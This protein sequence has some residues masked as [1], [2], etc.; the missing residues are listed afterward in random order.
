MNP[1][2]ILFS[3]LVLT[4]CIVVTFITHNKQT[5]LSSSSLPINQHWL[6]IQYSASKPFLW[7]HLPFDE[8]YELNA[9]ACIEL[10]VASILRH[11]Q[12]SFN[13]CIIDDHSFH[14][15]LPNWTVDIQSTPTTQKWSLRKLAI[16]KLL[17]TY[18]GICIPPSFFCL[19][20]L[21]HL[22]HTPM[23]V[24]TNINYTLSS[25]HLKFVPDLN[26]M[27]CTAGNKTMY[28]L[29]QFIA[30]QMST[31]FSDAIR[32]EDVYGKW[33][34]KHN[35]YI[36]QLSPKTL[37]VALEN[38][39]PIYPTTLLN[40]TYIQFD[41]SM[42]GIWIPIEQFEQRI[43]L[44]WFSKSYNIEE[45]TKSNTLLGKMMAT[46]SGLDKWTPKSLPPQWRDWV[47]FWEVPL[48]QGESNTW[49]LRPAFLPDNTLY[50]Q[51]PGKPQPL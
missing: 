26:L 44:Q 50:S 25:D 11:C 30:I 34:N 16:A 31:D 12:D 1:S 49:G 10:A 14:K 27:G 7:I 43:N 51:F 37:G 23:F 19:N 2:I 39:Q 28:Q 13:V 29:A 40:T 38:G 15:L 20:N 47:H 5:S 48:N 42:L 32:L 36:Q 33:I 24:G 18:G 3:L 17:F 35:K 46:G 41:P 21:N 4:I 22:I 6:H 8:H 9:P 45:I